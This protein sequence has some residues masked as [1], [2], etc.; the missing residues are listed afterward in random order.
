MYMK[1]PVNWGWHELLDLAG[2]LGHDG[3]AQFFAGL[4]QFNR[5]NDRYQRG[6]TNYEKD[7]PQREHLTQQASERREENSWSYQSVHQADRQ[8]P[9]P[10]R[11]EF[12]QIIKVTHPDT[13]F[14][15]S[16]EQEN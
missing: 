1:W 13:G 2:G 11:Q 8:K 10:L 6:E 9:S 3:H 7:D 15:H 14:G 5:D 16:Q 12:E 4:F